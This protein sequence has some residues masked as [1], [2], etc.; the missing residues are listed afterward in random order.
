MQRRNDSDY[1]VLGWFDGCCL[2]S[3]RTLVVM[4]RGVRWFV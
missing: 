1:D 3:Q 2:A 4:Q